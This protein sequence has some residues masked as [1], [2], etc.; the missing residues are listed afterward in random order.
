MGKL[1]AT[2]GIFGITFL[3]GR[4]LWTLT[5]IAVD[6]VQNY[7]LLWWHW[8]LMVSWVLFNAYAE[9]YRGFH[10]RFSPRTVARA[11]YLADH[12]TPLR[13]VL[14]PLFCMGL[15]GATKKVLI[16]SWGILVAVVLLVIWVR[17]MADPWRGIVDAGVVVGLGLGLLSIQ[18]YFV[19]GLFGR[20]V[21]HDPCVK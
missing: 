7:D 20:K 21:D 3:I 8:V 4:A 1:I 14:A 5:P 10:L 9:G 16:I 17:S 12:P 19:Q 15:F 2:W 18:G 13:V 11:F 6:T